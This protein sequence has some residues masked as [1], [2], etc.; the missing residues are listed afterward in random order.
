MSPDALAAILARKGYAVA[1]SPKASGAVVERDLRP[2]P[3]AAGE[4]EGGDTARFLVRV[5]SFR[6]RLL[7]EDNL[8][9]KY[10]VD[11]CRYAGFLPGDAPSTTHIETRQE[12]VRS[13]AEERTEVL[14]EERPCTTNHLVGTNT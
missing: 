12:K 10:V 2:R 5:T 7:D 14:I 4:I 1:D 8:C 13:K 3:L 9:E 11:C 6:R